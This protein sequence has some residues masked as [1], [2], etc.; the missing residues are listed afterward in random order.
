MFNTTEKIFAVIILIVATVVAIVGY[1]FSKPPSP[2]PKIWFDS[3]GGDIIFDHAYH[4]K[5][6]TCDECHHNYE[7]GATE[8]AEMSCRSCHY[9]G[10]ARELESDD[11][12][13]KRFIGAN[14]V[15]CH[16]SQGL[17]LRCDSC[18]IRQG[19]AYEESGRPTP[20]LPES[21][22]FETPNGLVIFNHELH[23]SSDDV[24]QTCVDCHHQ[25]KGGTDMFGME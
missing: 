11:P 9:F 19:Y 21:V 16:K 4:V 22:R 7:E 24:D 13:H 8:G 25:C 10:E 15:E 5:L 3:P 2:P 6:A 23:I 1:S 14:C 18:H 12:T 17:E 20:V